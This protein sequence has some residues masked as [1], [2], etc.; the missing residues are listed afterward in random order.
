MTSSCCRETFVR[1][2]PRITLHFKTKTILFSPKLDD[3]II[4]HET[5]HPD[6]IR[7]YFVLQGDVLN[8][9]TSIDNVNLPECNYAQQN[10]YLF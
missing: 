2:K 1:R 7:L 6:L 9:F 8:Q 10:I 3:S 4:E 5:T